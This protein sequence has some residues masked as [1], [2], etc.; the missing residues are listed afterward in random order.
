MKLVKRTDKIKKVRANNLVAGVIY[1]KRI[2]STPIQVDY[3]DFMQHYYKFGK[4]MTFKVT[5]EG[6][7]HQVYIKDIQFDPI[8]HQNVLH[9]DIIKVTASDTITANI[10]VYV[11]DKERLEEKGV[12][13][14]L[15]VSAIETE[16]AVGKGVSNF[17]VSVKDL[18][19]GDVVRV[20]DLDVAEG[21]K[22]LEDPE[23]MII[24]ITEPHYDESDFETPTSED[25]DMDVEAIKQTD[26]DEVDSDET[27]SDE[28]KEQD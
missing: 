8:N 2:E 12:I 7:N 26:E 21:L 6:K 16:Y 11:T 17:V 19:V 14:Q 13:V 28:E 24:N 23:R 1:G 10:P 22:I 15:I 27:N 18:D 4:S 3:K 20:K 5:F 9:F 25:E